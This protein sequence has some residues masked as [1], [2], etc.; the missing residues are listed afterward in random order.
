M[1]EIFLPHTTTATASVSPLNAAINVGNSAW[2]AY[3]SVYSTNQSSSTFSFF[4]TSRAAEPKMDR[5]DFAQEI[6]R[7]FASLSEGQ[8]PLGS[9]FEA[10]WDENLDV[11]YQS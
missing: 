7:V 10:V 6:A 4:E 3:K 11:L 5:H 2:P 8:E 9:E 1:N